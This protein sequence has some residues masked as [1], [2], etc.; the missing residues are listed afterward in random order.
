MK[1]PNENGVAT[2]IDQLGNEQLQRDAQ[3]LVD[4][5]RHLRDKELLEIAMGLSHVNA[6]HISVP[7]A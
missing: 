6:A 7:R 1:W 2:D 3:R 5:T 4:A